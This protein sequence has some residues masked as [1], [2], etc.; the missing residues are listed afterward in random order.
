MFEGWKIKDKLY[1]VEAL[2]TTEMIEIASKKNPYSIG[3][4][5][6]G[7]DDTWSKGWYGGTKS[8]DDAIDIF[9]KD[10]WLPPE[11]SQIAANVEHLFNK[12][13]ASPSYIYLDEPGIL[14]V[15]EYLTGSPDYWMGE[16][17]DIKLNTGNI[18]KS[19][20]IW[21]NLSASCAVEGDTIIKGGTMIFALI[22]IL[23]A[24]GIPTRLIASDGTTINYSS[25]YNDTRNIR[26]VHVKGFNQSLNSARAAFCVG[27]PAFFRRFGFRSMEN[28]GMDLGKEESQKLQKRFGVGGGYGYPIRDLNKAYIKENFGIDADIVLNAQTDFNFSKTPEQWIEAQLKEFQIIQ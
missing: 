10:A 27:N 21:T 2:D 26:V 20:T 8:V 5:S 7:K 3:N 13:I 6:E 15:G 24:K 17:A 12:Y 25:G 11:A 4:S 1:V 9:S 14:D 23:N 28:M 22:E 18:G 16:T 19:I